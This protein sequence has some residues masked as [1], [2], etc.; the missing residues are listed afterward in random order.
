MKFD[1]STIFNLLTVVSALI[2]LADIFFLEKNR[3]AA[4]YPASL[5]PE[6]FYVEFAK[7]LFPHLLGLQIAKLAVGELNLNLILASLACSSAFI[8]LLDILVLDKKRSASG[9]GKSPVSTPFYIDSAK[10]L[11]PHL[12]MLLALIWLA[13]KFDFAVLLTA[14]VFS[15]GLIWLIDVLFFAKS[16]KLM[17]KEG[18]EIAEP[19]LVD[20]AKSLFP[21]LVLVLTLRSFIAEP[22]RIPSGSMEPN[23]LVGDFILV[24][25]YNYGVRLPVLNKKIIEVG[26]PKRGDVVVFRYPG[27]GPDDETRGQDYI[28]RLIGLPGDEVT[29]VD[30]RVSINGVQVEYAP[31][32][33]Y[34]VIES[35][36]G[37]THIMQEIPNGHVT[38]NGTWKVPEGH[39]FMMG[40][41]RNNSSDGREW[42]FVPEENLVG[43]AMFI[44]LNCDSLDRL[45]KRSFD[46]SRIGDTIE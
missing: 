26:Q 17:Q 11:L 18:E 8:W 30:N 32:S 40:D 10:L 37:K 29:V 28:K 12:A 45:C 3:K 6:P 36:P 46:Y 34:Q 16:R 27:M 25:K 44:W 20:Y 38:K 9:D 7:V 39:Y 43:R 14:L 24:N 21:V 5:E 42:G 15:N 13:G 4:K 19:I 33:D 2:W 41:N 22:F 1:L 23:L 31:G 35:L